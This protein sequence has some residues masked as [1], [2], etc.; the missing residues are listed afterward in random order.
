VARRRLIQRGERALGPAR[1]RGVDD[2][3]VARTATVGSSGFVMMSALPLMAIGVMAASLAIAGCGRGGPVPVGPEATG[4]FRYGM[5]M[6][7]VER[8]SGLAHLD[9]SGREAGWCE[10][11]DVPLSAVDTISAMFSDERL[12]RVDVREGTRPTEA[13]VRIGDS[14]ARVSEVYGD[15]VSVTPHKYTQGHYLTVATGSGSA[16]VFETDG[17]LVTSYRAGLLPYAAWVEGCS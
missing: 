9:A 17:E 8:S 10:Y 15:R 12:V 4:P 16:L 5:G 11:R 13:G 2:R 7:E 14:E 1:S 6:D 3:I